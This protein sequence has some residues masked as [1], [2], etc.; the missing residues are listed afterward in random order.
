MAETKAA[1]APFSSVTSLKLG[2]FQ[3]HIA[4]LG[5]MW[6]FIQ[7][8]LAVAHRATITT[9]RK[10]CRESSRVLIFSGPA[11]WSS[12]GGMEFSDTTRLIR[13][14]ADSVSYLT[15]RKHGATSQ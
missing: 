6:A 9:H 2:I 15:K 8:M 1:S 7:N 13:S 4:E 11:L 12:N 14:C 3:S 5:Q 10:P